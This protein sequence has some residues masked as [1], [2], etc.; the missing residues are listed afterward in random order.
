MV[1]TLHH[2]CVLWSFT[3]RCDRGGIAHMLTNV[4]NPYSYLATSHGGTKNPTNLLFV[5]GM[6]REQCWYMEH[7]LV[8]LEHCVERLFSCAV[9]CKRTKKAFKFLTL[10]HT[11]IRTFSIQP[12]FKMLPSFKVYSF[13]EEIEK[14][15]KFGT[16]RFLKI[17]ITISISEQEVTVTNIM[18][19]FLPLLN[20]SSSVFWP[21]L[22]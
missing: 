9:V 22:A 20:I 7:Y 14:L 16:A 5:F 8:P 21:A 2:A 4:D 19:I 1:K 12:S 18:S 6:I 11:D 3:T 17:K 15:V 13:T 10:K